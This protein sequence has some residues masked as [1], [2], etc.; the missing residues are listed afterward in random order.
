LILIR[1]NGRFRAVLGWETVDFPEELSR[2]APR[3]RLHWRQ[4]QGQFAR[5]ATEKKYQDVG[6]RQRLATGKKFIA[7][8]LATPATSPKA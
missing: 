5:M 1:E 3:F 4:P 2:L 7:L 6:F 8:L